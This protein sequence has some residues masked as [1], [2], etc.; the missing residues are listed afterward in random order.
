MTTRRKRQITPAIGGILAG[1]DQQIMRT[2]PPPHELVHHARPDA[3][4][5]AADGGTLVIG[6]PDDGRERDLAERS[7][8]DPS[9]R[10]GT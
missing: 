1:F 7:P 4:V 2:T 8:G 6:F 3:P 5:P 9:A 10:T